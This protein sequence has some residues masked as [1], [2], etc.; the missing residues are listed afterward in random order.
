MRTAN[1]YAAFGEEYYFLGK[2]QEAKPDHLA[3]ATAFWQLTEELL[4]Q[5]QLRLGPLVHKREGGLA[6]IPQGLAEL[7]T[8][9]VTAGKLVYTVNTQ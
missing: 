2:P 1:S 8:G 5:D 7:K 6:A 4:R 9:G 3:F